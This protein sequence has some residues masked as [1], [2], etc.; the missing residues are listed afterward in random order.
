MVHWV[1]KK[2]NNEKQLQERGKGTTVSVQ[3]WQ[4]SEEVLMIHRSYSQCSIHYQGGA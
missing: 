1:T 4:L 2:E 3:T